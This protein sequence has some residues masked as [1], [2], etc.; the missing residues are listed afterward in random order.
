MG[1]LLITI[2]ATNQKPEQV[3]ANPFSMQHLFGMIF[4]TKKKSHLE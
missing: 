2:T 4:L 3:T 1:T